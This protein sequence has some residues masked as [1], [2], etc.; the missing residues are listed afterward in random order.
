MKTS[1]GLHGQVK[2]IRPAGYTGLREAAADIHRLRLDARHELALARQAREEATHYQQTTA[3]RAR[4]EAQQVILK[5]RMA[6]NRE[7]ETLRRVGEEI[8]KVLHDLGVIRVTAQEELAAQRRFMDAARLSLMSSAGIGGQTA[9]A[10]QP[11]QPPPD[12]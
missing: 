9:A 2:A 5:A 7:L 10:D 1:S 3:I 6:T 11:E 12:E 4:S 8:Q